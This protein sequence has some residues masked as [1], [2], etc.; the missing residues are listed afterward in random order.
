M[1][2]PEKCEYFIPLVVDALLTEDKAD[3]RVLDN[4]DKWYGVTY[5]EDKEDVVRAFNEFMEKGIYPKNF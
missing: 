5:K 3:V 4:T 1:V 2:N